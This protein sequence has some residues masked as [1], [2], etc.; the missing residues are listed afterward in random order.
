MNKIISYLIL[1]MLFAC[2]NSSSNPPKTFTFKVKNFSFYE[3]KTNQWR[4]VRLEIADSN[5]L[6]LKANDEFELLAGTRRILMKFE[7]LASENKANG[8]IIYFAQTQYNFDTIQSDFS[9]QMY[10]VSK[11]TI[12]TPPSNDNIEPSSISSTNKQIF[13]ANI[14]GKKFT[15]SIATMGALYYAKGHKM[16]DPSGKPYFLLAFVC[17]QLPD[18]RQLTIHCKNFAAGTGI[19]KD[20]DALFSGSSTG[21][22]SKSELQGCQNN[23]EFPEQKTNFTVNIT[24]WENIDENSAVISGTISG[25]LKGLLGARGIQFTD[26][27][28]T[29]VK[30]QIFNVVCE[31]K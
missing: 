25:K 29:N 17:N 14:E 13:T 12:I 16:M 30:V 21:D 23:P 5:K 15:A 24:K 9:A 31:G 18:N 27:I 20:M 4:R 10:I 8:S 7:S 28:F 19:L 3:I 1:A 2:G 22:N 26:G 11:G 6:N